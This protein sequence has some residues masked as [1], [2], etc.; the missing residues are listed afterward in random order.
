[1]NDPK[2]LS[3]IYSRC[4]LEINETEAL[5][6]YKAYWDKQWEEVIKDGV[7]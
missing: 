2:T 3:I 6:L 7:C 5:E 4:G 1:M